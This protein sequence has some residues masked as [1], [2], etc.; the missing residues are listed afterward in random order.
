M[1]KNPQLWRNKFDK[2][3]LDRNEEVVMSTPERLELVQFYFFFF[4]QEKGYN[5]VDHDGLKTKTQH[6]E[7][8]EEGK[9]SHEVYGIRNRMDDG[10]KL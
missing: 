1:L 3:T 8:S 6:S 2:K 4:T 5:V 7:V 10:K 9:L